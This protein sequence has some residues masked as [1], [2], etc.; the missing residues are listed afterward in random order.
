MA[1]RGGCAL[2]SIDAELQQAHEEYGS[3]K[4]KRNGFLRPSVVDA[5]WPPRVPCIDDDRRCGDTP[6]TEVVRAE[7]IC[8]CGH[9]NRPLAPSSLRP[10]E[11]STAVPCVSCYASRVVREPPVA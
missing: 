2:P 7:T 6:S 11:G 1:D 9:W 3:L 5:A 10:L 4:G 8:P